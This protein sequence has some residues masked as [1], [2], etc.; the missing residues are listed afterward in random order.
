MK[1]TKSISSLKETILSWKSGG[2][3][4]GFVPTMGFLHAGHL[5]LVGLSKK[6]S[7]KTVVSIFVNP[8]Q[9]NDP[10]DFQNYPIDL[11]KD[12]DILDKTGVDML[13]LPL[14]EEL[15]PGGEKSNQIW[16]IP[17]K[18]DKYLCGAA[19][20][21]HFRGVLTV[22]AK[23]F[24]QVNPDIA[25]FGKKDWQQARIIE[26]MT[27]SLFFPIEIILGET[28]REDDGLAMSSRNVRLSPKDRK[29]AN[30]IYKSL[31]ETKEIFEQGET[32]SEK[33]RNIL[34]EK[35]SSSQNGEIDYA[36]IVFRSDLSPCKGKI[37]KGGALM[38]VALFYGDV[39]L[40]D[41]MEI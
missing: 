30:I 14:M 8:T 10:R 36:E 16:V 32:D 1:I 31:R 19:R 40:I 29:E 18:L 23:F 15:Y 27:K 37:E 26:E 24:H 22:V 13:Y 3:I 17:E 9:F 41:N 11:D 2:E 35:L 25:F 28:I 39:R 38:A 34:A 21:G 20:P 6:K 33:L 7:D 5:S 4:I 12:S